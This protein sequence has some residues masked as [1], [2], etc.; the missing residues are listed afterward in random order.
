MSVATSTH[1]IARQTLRLLAARKIA[2]TPENYRDL[3]TEAAGAAEPDA[4]PAAEKA[5]RRLCSQ[6]FR[7]AARSSPAWAAP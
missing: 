2:P 1:E 7:A 6:S 4:V 3:Y 5:L